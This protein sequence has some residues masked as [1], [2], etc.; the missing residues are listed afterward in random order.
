[1]CKGNSGRLQ[2]DAKPRNRRGSLGSINSPT[3]NV[4]R[5]SG[6]AREK[7]AT[8]STRHGFPIRCT[9]DQIYAKQCVEEQG[10]DNDLIP[11]VH[12]VYRGTRQEVDSYQQRSF[13]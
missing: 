9:R 7:E 6:I 13:A 3:H 2:P 12:N 1:M 5:S 8:R 4:P 11:D 10:R